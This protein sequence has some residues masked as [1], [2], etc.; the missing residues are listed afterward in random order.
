[1]PSL[2]YITCTGEGSQQLAAGAAEAVTSVVAW[3]QASTN[4]RVRII[5]TAFP[6]RVMYAGSWQL[7]SSETDPNAASSICVH[8]SQPIWFEFQDTPVAYWNGSGNSSDRI[9][10]KL[11]PGVTVKLKVWW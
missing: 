2:G 11:A 9:M 3:L 1:V 10:W 8:H 6:R 5:G 4:P 7:A